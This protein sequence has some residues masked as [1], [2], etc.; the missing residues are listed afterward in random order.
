[1]KLHVLILLAAALTG[2]SCKKPDDSGAFHHPTSFSFD[3]NIPFGVSKHPGQ[4]AVAYKNLGYKGWLVTSPDGGVIGISVELFNLSKTATLK[5]RNQPDLIPIGVAFN[6]PNEELTIGIGGVPLS[7]ITAVNTQPLKKTP[8]VH[9]EIPPSSAKRF[10]IPI[11]PLLQGLPTMDRVKQCYL[12]IR[13]N[14]YPDWIPGEVFFEHPLPSL[15]FQKV[16]I[17][18]Q[19]LETDPD[20]ALKEAL[21]ASGGGD[22]SEYIRPAIPKV[23]PKPNKP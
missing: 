16:F 17:T 14:A 15:G 1:M 20:Q 10:Y 2:T 21:A 22:A 7:G 5:M 18:K 9:W 8:L 23:Q 12:M 11:R 3:Q 6:C 13:L 4:E 19:A